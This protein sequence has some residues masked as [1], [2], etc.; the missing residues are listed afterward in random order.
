MLVD[1]LTPAIAHAA[2]E[3]EVSGVVLGSG[4]AADIAA[5]L[6]QVAAGHSVFPAGWMGAV[7]RAEGE[8]LYC[9]LSERQLRCSS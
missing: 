5:S 2:L 6:A 7:R 4:T 3:R 8:S 1:E 9:V